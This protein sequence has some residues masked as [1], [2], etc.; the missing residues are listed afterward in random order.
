MPNA[1]PA[2]APVA[3]VTGA[4]RGIGLAVASALVRAGYRVALTARDQ[5][6]LSKRCQSLQKHGPVLAIAADLR[7]ASVPERMLA[8][9]RSQF[10]P[11]QVI[12]NNAGTAPSDRFD[13][14]SDESLA[15]ALDLHVWAPFR[16]LRLQPSY[17]ILK[18][19]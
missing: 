6:L 2:H 18:A 13:K 16:L 11:P 4:S 14:T 8:E 15:A 19:T 10:G 5:N 12:I 1:D 17:S 7:D 3:L 9:V